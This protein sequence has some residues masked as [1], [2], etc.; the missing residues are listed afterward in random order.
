MLPALGV[1]VSPEPRQARGIAE[2]RMQQAPGGPETQV[3]ELGLSCRQWA[4]KKDA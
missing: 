2:K 1:R 3:E 4:V